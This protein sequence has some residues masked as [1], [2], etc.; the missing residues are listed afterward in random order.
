VFET[1]TRKQF[2]RV[3]RLWAIHHYG[4]NADDDSVSKINLLIIHHFILFCIFNRLHCCIIS[5]YLQITDHYKKGHTHWEG[6]SLG[7]SRSSHWDSLW[8]R[9]LIHKENII[10]LLTNSP[11]RKANWDYKFEL[12]DILLYIYYMGFWCIYT[13]LR[14][15]YLFSYV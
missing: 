3:L 10:I 9:W 12:N 2:I 6:S 14:K 7:N 4:G 1:R 8:T 15:Y 11:P 13:S 5:T